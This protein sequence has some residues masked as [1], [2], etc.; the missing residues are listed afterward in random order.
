MDFWT[1]LRLL[2]RRWYVWTI[3]LLVTVAVAAALFTVVKPKYNA[4]SDFLLLVPD[5]E[6]TVNE[7]QVRLN[8]YLSYGSG[9]T[10]TAEALVQALNGDEVAA[11]VE[12]LGGSGIF[13]AQGF[14]GSAPIVTLLVEADSQTAALTTLGL[15]ADQLERALADRQAAAQVRD[16]QVI[17]ASALRVPLEAEKDQGSRI[18]ALAGALAVG[19]VL[20]IFAA[21]LLDTWLTDRRRRAEEARRAAASDKPPTPDDDPSGAAEAADVRGSSGAVPTGR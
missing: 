12:G 21:F 14:L 16:N 2:R 5:Q 11:V 19:I 9:L 18:R 13:E 3:G 20:S 15:Y 8:P 6:F 7:R 4:T 17:V 1:A 10:V